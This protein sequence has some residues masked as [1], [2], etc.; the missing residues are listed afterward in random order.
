MSRFGGP[1]NPFLVVGDYD[2]KDYLRAKMLNVIFVINNSLKP[3]VSGVSSC[4]GDFSLLFLSLLKPH[5]KYGKNPLSE[6]RPGAG[7]GE[8]LH[9]VHEGLQVGEF[10]AGF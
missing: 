1:V 6:T 5:Q 2:G 7:L 4:F 9:R 3:E 10:H 8:G